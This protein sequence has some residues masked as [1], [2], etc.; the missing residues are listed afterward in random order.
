M[1]QA[2]I[3]ANGNGSLLGDDDIFDVLD[4]LRDVQAQCFNIGTRLKL[5]PNIIEG[6]ENDKLDHARSLRKVINNWLIKRNYNVERF[7]E[8][9]WKTLVQAVENPGGGN[10]RAL[11]I[12]IA[13]RHQ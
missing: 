3:I 7:G 4:E 1:W 13:K 8:P 5:R 12:K 6:I 10:D 2:V 9:C 11:A